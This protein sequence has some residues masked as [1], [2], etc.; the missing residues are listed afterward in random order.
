MKKFTFRFQRLLE[1]RT[2]YKRAIAARLAKLEKRRHELEEET[3]A[4]EKEWRL[5]R[6]KLLSGM[7][8]VLQERKDLSQY[9][10]EIENRL[11]GLQRSRYRLLLEI[12]GT[13]RDFE[14]ASRAEQVLEKLRAR[15]FEEHG[16]RLRKAEQHVLDEIAGQKTWRENARMATA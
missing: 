14:A 13:R 11:A 10:A 6:H 2:Q 9:L 16:R 12:D 8:F 15:Q 3:A 5:Y 4:G 1:L 7:S